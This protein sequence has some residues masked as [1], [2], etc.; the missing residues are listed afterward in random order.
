[1]CGIVFVFSDHC[2]RIS[3]SLLSHR[4]PDKH[5]EYTS[6]KHGHLFVF[7]RLAINGIGSS[8]DQP[9]V[10]EDDVLICN[11]EIYNH[12]ELRGTLQE[13]TCDSTSD[14]AVL[15]DMLRNTTMMYP[16]AF[17]LVDGEFA[18]VYLNGTRNEIVVA[19]DPFGVRP[20]FIA[21]DE[22]TGEIVGFASEAKAF[23]NRNNRVILTQFPPG[24]YWT[25]TTREYIPYDFSRNFKFVP[26][27]FSVEDHTRMV[28]HLVTKAVRS[29]IA[30][31]ERSRPAFFLSGGLDS[32]IVAAIAASLSSEPIDTF[33][34]GTKG[35]SPDLIAAQIMANHIGSRHTVVEFTPE[36]AVEYIPRVIH[37]LESYDCT[38]VRAS[39]PMYIL[40]EY[41]AK[42]TNHKVVLSGEGADEV[43]GGY[44]YFHHAPTLQDFHNETIRLV[45]QIHQYDGLRADRCTAGNGLELRVPFLDTELVDYVTTRVPASMKHP[46]ENQGV[47][48]RILR[49][50]FASILPPEILH[51]QKNGMSDAVGYDWV[52]HLRDNASTRFSK[53]NTVFTVNPPQTDE[54][55]WYRQLHDSLFDSTAVFAHDG[56]WRPRWTT[57][58]DPSARCLTDLFENDKKK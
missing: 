9:I 24:H 26:N 38:T 15:F 39:V 33:S 7:D 14:C 12:D 42:N 13:R 34:I 54:E 58:T 32:S 49:E 21:S 51:R 36:E 20:L 19:R 57:V 22:A 41:I 8:G 2:H 30:M 43:F 31:N 1:M 40:S 35:G 52:N 28:Q 27:E 50:A 10:D 6:S 17:R 48:K 56:I 23:S 46:R 18:C 55:R 53:F 3:R 4:G 11:G 29:R 45:S 44:L 37:Q 25:S 47:E 5:V 16:R